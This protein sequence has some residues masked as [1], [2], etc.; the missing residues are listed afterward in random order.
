M[1]PWLCDPLPLFPPLTPPSPMYDNLVRPFRQKMNSLLRALLKLDPTERMT[2]PE[3]FEFVDDLI[4]SKVEVI[5]LLHGTSF[6]FIFDP[7]MT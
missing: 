4:T 5:N 3:L 7:N 1:L 6:K 2:F